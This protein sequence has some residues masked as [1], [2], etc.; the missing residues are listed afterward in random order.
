MVQ[1]QITVFSHYM[2]TVFS[3]ICRFKDILYLYSMSEAAEI[4]LKLLESKT[5]TFFP[6]TLRTHFFKDSYERHS[7]F[8]MKQKVKTVKNVRDET[9]WP[10]GKKV[11]K[12]S[13]IRV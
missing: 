5:R 8:Y 10:W 3:I 13:T 12:L 6:K 7:H 2:N 11:K 1:L 9:N 4:S